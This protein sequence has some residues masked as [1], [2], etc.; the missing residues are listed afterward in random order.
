MTGGDW[1]RIVINGT[2]MQQALTDW[3]N[4]ENVV[5][6]TGGPGGKHWHSP[7]MVMTNAPHQCNP[8]CIPAH[9]SSF[10]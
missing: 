9:D 8:S 10:F 5:E 4:D 6:A 1:Q 2:S 3:W 7:C